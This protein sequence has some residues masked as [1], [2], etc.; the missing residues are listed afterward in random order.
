MDTT[1]TLLEESELGV[2][3]SWELDPINAITEAGKWK[4]VSDDT[5]VTLFA[6]L[7]IGEEIQ[8]LILNITIKFVEEQGGGNEQD[9]VIK[10]EFKDGTYNQN[11]S[12]SNKMEQYIDDVHSKQVTLTTQR[13]AVNK[14]SWMNVNALIFAANTSSDAF[15]E[16]DLGDRVVESI[17]FNAG[18]WNEAGKTQTTTIIIEAYINGLWVEIKSNFKE[19]ISTGSYALINIDLGNIDGNFSKF[20]I[21]QTGSHSKNDGRI[22]IDNIIVNVFA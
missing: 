3:I 4:V 5:N 12:T 2:D 19:D 17:K 10:H 8:E 15:V 22:A 16:F 6:T 13:V 20:R 1:I 9:D 18:Y 7:T 14:T 21:Y 11:Y